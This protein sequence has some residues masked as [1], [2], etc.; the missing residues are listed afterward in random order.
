MSEWP[1]LHWSRGQIGSEE[2]EQDKEKGRQKEVKGTIDLIG[3]PH[4]LGGSYM[5]NIFHPALSL[6]QGSSIL[7]A[8]SWAACLRYG[9]SGGEALAS[10]S[11][12]LPLTGFR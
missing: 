1:P 8:T 6:I 12:N 11:D 2:E 7:G 3:H 9:D 10:I 4:S 5:G